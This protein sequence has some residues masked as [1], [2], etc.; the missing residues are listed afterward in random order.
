MR[1]E[2][3]ARAV[4]WWCWRWRVPAIP[5]PCWRLGWDRLNSAMETS[6][7][8]PG[9]PLDLEQTDCLRRLH[10]VPILHAFEIDDHRW[11]E[12]VF[13]EH[14]L[15]IFI[16]SR[17]VIPLAYAWISSSFTIGLGSGPRRSATSARVTSCGARWRAWTEWEKEYFEAGLRVIV[18]NLIF[19]SFY[20]LP[21]LNEELVDVA[22]VQFS[23]LFVEGVTDFVLLHV[24]KCHSKVLHNVEDQVI[25][26][27]VPV[28]GKFLS[29]VQLAIFRT[30]KRVIDFTHEEDAR[31]DAGKIFEGHL[32]L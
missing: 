27:I 29:Q 15:W 5:C 7:H 32:E 14:I 1:G 11:T 21:D 26:S 17:Q 20:A 13:L 9:D 23:C 16:K 19:W 8:G 2:W 4:E 24:Q 10:F 30:H 25:T 6:I 22:T 28:L 12:R 31:C 3:H 18:V